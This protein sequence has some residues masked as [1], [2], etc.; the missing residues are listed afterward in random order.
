[1]SSIACFCYCP[2]Y[3]LKD[4]CG[5][6]FKYTNGFKDCSDCKLP[7]LILGINQNVYIIYQNV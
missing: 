3:M 4:D 6:N 7:H 1:M 2:L 5:G